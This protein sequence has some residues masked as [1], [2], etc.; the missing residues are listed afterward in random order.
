[1]QSERLCASL[2]LWP[3][4]ASKNLSYPWNSV[5]IRRRAAGLYQTQL[6]EAVGV[7]QAVISNF[8]NH[9]SWPE[10]ATQV[11][12]AEALGCMWLELFIEPDAADLNALAAGSSPE[13]WSRMAEMVRI[14]RKS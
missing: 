6:A 14:M 10:A 5:R 13:E 12:I 2:I 8:E 9:K 4:P 7:T 11:A 3:M 1:M